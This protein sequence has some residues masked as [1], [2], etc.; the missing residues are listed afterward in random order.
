M[1]HSESDKVPTD[2]WIDSSDPNV[3]VSLMNYAGKRSYED[4]LDLLDI[5]IYRFKPEV[6]EKYKNS[7]GVS[8]F[9]LPVTDV[10][11]LSF[12]NDS[13]QRPLLKLED[14][15]DL[16]ALDWPTGELFDY[17]NFDAIL[18]S[19]KH[20]VLWAQAGTWSPMFCKMCDL[21]G[22]EKVMVDLLTNGDFVEALARKILAFYEDSFRR[23]LEASK[24]RL[25]VFGFGDDL[26]TQRGL[27]FG[28]TYWHQFFKEPMRRLVE[29]IKSYGVYVAFHSCG[30][31]RDIIP[32]FIDMGVDILFPIQPRAAGMEASSLK[33]DFGRDIVFYGGIDVQHTL[34]FG[35][36][37]EVRDE[38]GRVSGILAKDGGY[39]LASSHGILKDVP[40]ANVV[41]MYDEVNILGAKNGNN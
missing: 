28:L 31:I 4:L 35:T 36:E 40:P 21:C 15:K 17:S 22:M 5:D 25:D 13:I 30:A 2:L 38:V 39:I 24:G 18:E 16:D 11:M 37:R 26:A 10:G 19:Q 6:S 7:G 12:S 32:D 20:R 14:P 1:G 27:M 8:K 33:K 34:P 9:F 3:K 29:L 41:A 23:T